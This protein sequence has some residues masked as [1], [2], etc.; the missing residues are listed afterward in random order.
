VEPDPKVFAALADAVRELRGFV[1]K[2]NMEPPNEADKA[3]EYN[4]YSS[5]GS[6]KN[7]LDAL[8][9][10]L[11][12]ARRIAKKEAEGDEITPEDYETIKEIARGFRGDILLPGS[13]QFGGGAEEQLKMALV[14]DIAT[15][16]VDGTALYAATGTPRKIYVFVNDGSGGARLARGYVYSYYEF[17]RPL[18]EGRMTDEEWKKLVYDISRAEELKEYRPAWHGE[19]EK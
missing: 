14:A 11:E 9:E 1:E 2:Y 15:N 10:L 7:K 19:L 18:G 6:Y 13:G 4:F 5:F 8:A 16:G 12:N 17:E 3:E